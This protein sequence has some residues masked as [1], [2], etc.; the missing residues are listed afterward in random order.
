MAT[1]LQ[2]VIILHLRFVGGFSFSFSLFYLGGTEGGG[3]LAVHQLR[4][5]MRDIGPTSSS[6]MAVM[7]Q[8][9][10]MEVQLG[11]GM[12][13]TSNHIDACMYVHDAGLLFIL[14]KPSSTTMYD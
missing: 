3:K 5:R 13:S 7:V 1:V 14:W 9:C 10:M 8:V 4:G 11:G 2:I 6:L 12:Y